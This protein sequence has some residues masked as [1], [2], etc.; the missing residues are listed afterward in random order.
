MEKVNDETKRC[1]SSDSSDQALKIDET[2]K[3]KGKHKDFDASKLDKTIEETIR[4]C[5]NFTPDVAK[6]MLLKLIKNEHILALSF[7]KAEEDEVQGSD[8]DEDDK[9]SEAE[10]P[11]TPKLT[12]LKAKQLNHKLP[13]PRNLNTPEPCKEVVDLIQGEMKSDDE[14]EEY[15]PCEEEAVS[16]EDA[17]NTTFSDLESQP[18]TPGSALLYNEQDFESPVKDGSEFK[19]PKTRTLSAVSCNLLS[20][21][22]KSEKIVLFCRKNKKTSQDAPGQSFACKPRRSKPSSPPSSHQ[23]SPLTCMISIKTMKSTTSGGNFSLNS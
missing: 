4:K 14:D 12:R 2:P 6:K 21:Y 11:S 23:T 1:E 17:T 13:V 3:K 5:E 7:L 9:K 8:S 15:Q 20:K 22:V 10:A 19:V 16:D 18:S